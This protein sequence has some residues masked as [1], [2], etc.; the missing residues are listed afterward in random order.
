MTKQ[1][2]IEAIKTFA[3]SLPKHSYLRPWLDDI[4]PIVESDIL[5]DFVINVQTRRQILDTVGK[6]ASETI[7]AAKRQ[8]LAIVSKSNDEAAR[9]RA[10][11]TQAKATAAARLRQLAETID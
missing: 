1:Q 11:F 2:E 9:I 8:A 4:M 6:E 3:A 5:S 10:A 7:E